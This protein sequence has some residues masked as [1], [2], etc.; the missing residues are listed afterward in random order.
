MSQA[1]GQLEWVRATNGG[2]PSTGIA[3]GVERDGRPLFIARAFYKNGLH[4]GK[5]APHLSNGGFE[6]AWGGGSH[7]LNEYFVLCGNVNRTR[8]VAV[9]GPVPKDTSL[10]LVDGGQEDYGD[11]LFIAKVAHDGRAPTCATA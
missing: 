9:D 10:R 7:S 4:P 11:R 5:A 8:W 6:F 2:I 1:P 3:Q